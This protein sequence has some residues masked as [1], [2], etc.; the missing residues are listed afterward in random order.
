MDTHVLAMLVT[1]STGI[2]LSNYMQQKLWLPIGAEFDA[3][4]IIDDDGMEIAF[5]CLNAALRDYLKFGW[6]QLEW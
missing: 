6:W 2:T 1:H 3:Q 4:W 5:G